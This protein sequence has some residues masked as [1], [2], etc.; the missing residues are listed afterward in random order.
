M[1]GRPWLAGHEFTM[2]DCAAAPALFYAQ[3]F[4]PVAAEQTHLT[5]YCASLRKRPSVAMV[6]EEARPF[7]HFYPLQEGLAQ[8]FQP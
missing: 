6:L 4:A 7:L 8:E 1:A 5:A 3:T 2:A